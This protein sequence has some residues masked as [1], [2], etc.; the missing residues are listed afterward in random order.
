[1][2]IRDRTGSEKSVIPAFEKIFE[3]AS[4]RLVV[5]CFATSIHRLQIVFDLAAEFGRSV[6]LLGRSMIRN[7]ET[8]Q[9]YN[10]LDVEDG[11]IVT[12]AQA[13]K[14]SCLLYTSDAADERSSVD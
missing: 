9:R 5:T 4:G 10:F 3:D 2:C 13:K 1:M 11:Q 6:A 7:V 8:A 12:P 14:L